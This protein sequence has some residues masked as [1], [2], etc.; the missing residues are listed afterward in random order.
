MSEPTTSVR[1]RRLVMRVMAAR[2]IRLSECLMNRSYSRVCRRDIFVYYSDRL[3]RQPDGATC[4]GDRRPKRP[5]HMRQPGRQVRELLPTVVRSRWFCPQ[6]CSGWAQKDRFLAH[7]RAAPADA[8]A[9]SPHY[10]GS[11][12]R[13]PH[14]LDTYGDDAERLG[15]GRVLITGLAPAE[16]GP[17]LTTE[18]FAPVLA[19]LKLPR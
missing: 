6:R 9:R 16:P 14:A 10:P 12:D 3:A 15:A 11:H 17:A 5:H 7:L 4:A 2:V 18:H 1:V 19:V 13:S 8:P